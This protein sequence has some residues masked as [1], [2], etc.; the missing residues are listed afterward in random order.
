M[1][2]T[3][4]TEERI[5]RTLAA[6]TEKAA[7]REIAA[8][9]EAKD[10]RIAELEAEKEQMREKAEALDVLVELDVSCDAYEAAT[11]ALSEAH[12]DGRFGIHAPEEV[13]ARDE[14]Q[15][16]F[17][18]ARQQHSQLMDRVATIAEAARASVIKAD[19]S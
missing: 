14:A 13:R 2:E 11:D 15:N 19:R 12:R 4:T 18:K 17:L 10:K 3:Q 6:Y 7:A 9:L 16:R 5:Y 8:E 1:G